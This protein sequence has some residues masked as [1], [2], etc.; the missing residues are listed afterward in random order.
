M[1]TKISLFGE[2]IACE[3]LLSK[4][5]SIIDR[6][7]RFLHLEVDIIA[8]Y[9]NT[10]VFV[11]VKTRNCKFT[12]NQIL[13]IS[14]KK[15]KNLLNVARYFIQEYKDYDEIRFDV[16]FVNKSRHGFQINH[17]TSA[18]IPKTNI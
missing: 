17:I 18:F 7:W 15:Q 8:K 6:N 11:E 9:K 1:R 2:N 3:Y 5:F 10:L 14:K 12:D 4:G 13:T 16:I